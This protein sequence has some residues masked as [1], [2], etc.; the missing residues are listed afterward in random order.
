VTWLDIGFSWG[1]P[2]NSNRWW[3]A[4]WIVTVGFVD[5]RKDSG[6]LESSIPSK[7]QI[8]FFSFFFLLLHLLLLLRRRH[9]LWLYFSSF[10]S[11]LEKIVVVLWLSDGLDRPIGLQE[12]ATPLLVRLCRLLTPRL[13]SGSG[14]QQKLGWRSIGSTSGGW[15]AAPAKWSKASPTSGE[16]CWPDDSSLDLILRDQ[17]ILKNQFNFIQVDKRKFQVV[18]DWSIPSTIVSIFVILSFST[19]FLDVRT[20]PCY[21]LSGL[22]SLL[23][24]LLNIWKGSFVTQRKEWTFVDSII[25]AAALVHGDSCN[26]DEVSRSHFLEN[27]IMWWR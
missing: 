20:F 11:F 3:P 12:C 17:N 8:F 24:V 13:R 6:A 21:R 23:L 2:T 19:I 7:T 5:S 10:L 27:W 15:A 14:G 18:N 16:Q 25:H 1:D 22:Y 4:G 9:L 26:M